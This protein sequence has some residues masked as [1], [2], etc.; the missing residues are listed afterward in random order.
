MFV[1]GV[2]SRFWSIEHPAR[3]Y[4]GMVVILDNGVTSIDVRLVHSCKKKDPS[5]VRYDRGL[6]SS[7]FRLVHPA[8]NL[9]G[10]E[11]PPFEDDGGVPSGVIS[12]C[13]R[14]TDPR[15]NSVNSEM[16]FE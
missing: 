8:R 14:F 16:A 4:A 11:T 10:S 3:K 12:T 9:T 13:V 6:K 5:S 15:S 7:V 2:R 1:S